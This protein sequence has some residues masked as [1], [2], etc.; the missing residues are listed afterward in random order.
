MGQVYKSVQWSRSTNLYNGAGVQI[1]TMGQEN[2]STMGQQYKSVYWDS[3]TNLYNETGVQ[4]NSVQWDSSTNLYNGTG[5]QIC[6]MVQEH[7]FEQCALVQICTTGQEFI[8][9][10]Q[11]KSPN[12]YN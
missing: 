2:K 1:Y 3:S 6:T 5:V 12:L 7:K 11:G 9:E 10:K 4:Y 8:S